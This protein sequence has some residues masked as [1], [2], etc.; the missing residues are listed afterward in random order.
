[1]Q[2]LIKDSENGDLALFYLGK[3]L[4]APESPL[5]FAVAVT[6]INIGT[7]YMRLTTKN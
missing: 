7:R 4:A 2:D 5:V 3:A 6:A 1:M